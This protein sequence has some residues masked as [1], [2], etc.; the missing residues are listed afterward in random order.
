MLNDSDLESIER[1]KLVKGSATNLITLII[2]H[3]TNF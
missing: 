1:L 3:K 2:P